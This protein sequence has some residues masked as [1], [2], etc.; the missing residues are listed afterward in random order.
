MPNKAQWYCEDV[1]GRLLT[2]ND[3][4]RELRET[5][6]IYLHCERSPQSAAER[7]HIARNTV[8]YRVHRAEELL[9]HPISDPM[10][11]LLA[12]EIAHARDNTTKPTSQQDTDVRFHHPVNHGHGR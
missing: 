10:E 1:L 11:L 3:R 9:G 5:L 8:T 6:R 12:L 7:L 4:T 2:D